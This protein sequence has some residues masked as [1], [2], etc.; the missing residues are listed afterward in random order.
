MINYMIDNLKNLWIKLIKK[1]KNQPKNKKIL[2]GSIFLVLVFA[3][4]KIF[5]RNDGDGITT[6]KVIRGDLA[7]TVLA[8]GQIVSSANFDLSFYKSGTVRNVRVSVSDKV[9]EGA[10]LATLDQGKELA[11]LTSARGAEAAARAKYQKILDGSSSEEIMLAEVALLNAKNDFERVKSQQEIL[12]Q[13]AYKDL[14]NSTPEARPT[15]TSSS[16][17]YIAPVISGN[18]SKDIEGDIIVSLYQSGTGQAFGLRG[19]TQGEGIVA[20]ITAQPLGDSGLYISFSGVDVNNVKEW[21]ISIPNK[22]ASDYQTNWNAY[23]EAL[24]TKN[25]AIGNAE[26]LINQRK[27]EL[28]IKQSSATPADLA[29]AEADI[30]SA[31]GQ[32]ENARADFEYTIIRAPVA[33]TITRVDIKPGELAQSSKAVIALEDVDNLF[34]EV[35]INESD[36]TYL[37][38]GQNADITFDAFGESRKFTGVV[39]HI[40]PSA[41]TEDGIVNYKIKVYLGDQNPDIRIGMNTNVKILA[42]EVK[43]ALIIPFVAIFEREG[44]SFA[45]VFSESGK[46]EEREIITGFRGENNMVEIISGLSLGEEVALEKNPK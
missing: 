27:A 29:L 6:E 22:K 20:S 38:V 11:A 5:A 14:L 42:G 16:G 32:L 41:V 25:L 1:V 24:E 21:T 9:N 33:G 34:I 39:A 2:Y 10:I 17:N 7:E 35:P 15:S 3:S 40:D 23:Q 44:K 45:Q 19:L 12:T 8:T 30:L 46:F 37:K 28:S 13:N 43:N 36:I 31:R 4:Y 26:A 18:Y